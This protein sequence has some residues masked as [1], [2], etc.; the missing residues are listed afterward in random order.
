MA[1]PDNTPTD[2]GMLGS[3]CLLSA[4]C[5]PGAGQNPFSGS[6]HR[7]SAETNLTSIHE[8]AGW[9]PGLTSFC[10]LRIH[11]CREL[12]CRSRTQLGSSIAGAVVEASDYSSDLT[13]RL[14][15]STC[16]RCGSMKT[17]DKKTPKTPFSWIKRVLTFNSHNNYK[18]KAAGEGRLAFF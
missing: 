2:T 6:S 15:T 3:K 4:C 11:G 5:V 13:P 17:K 7:G 18:R 9:I 10:G 8:A 1:V 12:W 16:R 14:G